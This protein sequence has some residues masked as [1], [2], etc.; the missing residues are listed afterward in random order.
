MLACTI[1]C[2]HLMVWK[3]FAPK[4][5]YE[6][7]ASYVTFGAILVGYLIMM[8]LHS[9]Y[10]AFLRDIAVNKKAFDRM[11]E[12]KR[13]YNDDVNERLARPDLND[14]MAASI[15]KHLKKN[16]KPHAE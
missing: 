16:G 12:T 10:G 14:Q 15:A 7:I 9:A 4:F 5:I 13:D 6:G 11:V 3:V 2:R 1:H 8:R